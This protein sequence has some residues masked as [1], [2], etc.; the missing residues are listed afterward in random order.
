MPDSIGPGTGQGRMT[1][2]PATPCIDAAGEAVLVGACLFVVMGL[3]SFNVVLPLIANAFS[4]NAHSA[5]LSQIAGTV[6]GLAFALGSPVIGW[7]IERHGYKRVL[8]WSAF[9]FALAGTSIM[10]LNSLAA[11]IVA[12]AIIGVAVGGTQIAALTGL[13]TLP[14]YQRARA[15]GRYTLA[16]GMCSIVFVFAI[17][18]LAA[19]S[20]RLPFLLHLV[21]L[22]ALPFIHF[23]LPQ[24]VNAPVVREAVRIP[25]WRVLPASF[26]LLICFIGMINFIPALFG[27]FYLQSIG[28]TDPALFGLPMMA[29]SAIGLS[30]AA[31][32][33]RLQRRVGIGG[34]W[35]VALLIVG[36][37][38][39]AASISYSLWTIIISLAL[40]GIGTTLAFPNV[41][42][43]AVS[44]APTSHSRALAL[45]N[46][47]LFG[48]P[49]LLPS[50]ATELNG[51]FGPAAIFRLYGLA[52]VVIALGFVIAAA[53]GRRRRRS[54]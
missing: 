27:P 18:H 35:S 2:S 11:I 13:S 17:G 29:Q 32:Y 16:S 40:A 24:H 46:G 1:A 14:E 47:L 44:I 4:Y 49:I 21:G 41:S 23:L 31:I 22:I 33:A 39:L 7:V 25:A 20:W 37:G 6:V 9:T 52:S 51:A 8:L 12:R 43:S 26:L 54:V 28:I 38:F 19:V 5:M 50:I 36:I 3:F 42:A 30:G 45:A 10:M 15:L 53:K 48:A 34:V